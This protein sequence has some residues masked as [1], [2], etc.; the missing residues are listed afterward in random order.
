[1]GCSCG[2]AGA[3]GYEGARPFVL[4]AL[5]LSAASGAAAQTTSGAISGIVTDSARRP[6]QG[7]TIRI[8]QTEIRRISNANGEFLLEH[9]KPGAYHLTATMIGARPARDSVVVAPGDTTRVHFALRLIPIVVETLPPRFARGTRP[10]TAPAESETIDLVARVG[11]IPLLRAR[12]P[13]G[14]RRE[15]RFWI[16][17]GI[18]IPM[19]LVRLTI[20]GPR[21]RGEVVRYLVETLPDSQADPHWRA[22]MD[23]VPAWLRERFGCGTVATDTLHYPTAQPGYRD[24]LVAVC[25]S[26]FTREPDWR[27]LLRELEAHHVWTLPDNSELPS[28]AN[29]VSVDGDGVTTEA[30]T[31]VRYHSYTFGATSL[32]PAPEAQHGEAIHR[33]LIEFVKR[34]HNDLQPASR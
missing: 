7:V 19:E 29:V 8:A 13:T 2:S 9:L 12:P 3:R 4:F 5:A 26:R 23:S 14:G 31:G 30:W 10:D 28:L 32:I 27:A 20:D 15:L 17:G 22:F 6:M 18:A 34:V 24:E 21:V 33:A 11:R 25:T 16:G 1:M